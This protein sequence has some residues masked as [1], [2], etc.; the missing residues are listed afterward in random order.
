MSSREIA[1][2][3]PAIKSSQLF[4]GVAE[5]ELKAML[6]CLE[7]RIATFDKGT[8]ILRA[9]DTID[10]IGLVLHGSVL[11]E[12]E[13]I[14]GNRNIL[15]NARQGQTFA[16]TVAC[17]VGQVLESN[18]VA[19][20]TTTVM[21]LN[22]KRVLTVCSSACTHHS[23]IVRNLL[24]ELAQKNLHLNEKLGHMSHRTTRRKLLSYLSSESR[25]HGSL[26]FDIPFTRQQLADYLAVDRSG[27]S[28]ELSKMQADGILEFR[29][30]HFI[31][32]ELADM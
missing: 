13:D 24:G 23:R 18:V 28:I 14:W 16:S 32:S 29:K 19:D 20:C 8:Y 12:Q 2:Y 10:S 21:F 1:K 7:V 15:S 4:C 17:A 22:V 25:R 27:L 6:Q 26:E 30:N 11:I 3:Y 9:G 5:D 31:L